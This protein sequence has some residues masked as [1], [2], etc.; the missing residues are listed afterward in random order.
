MF[1]KF[2]QIIA[3]ATLTS[4]AAS[5]QDYSAWYANQVQNQNAY[6]NQLTNSVVQQ[7]MQNPYVQR[8]YQAHL[9][10]GGG[11]SFEQ[12]C[13]L[14]GATGGFSQAGIAQY[15]NVTRD[16]VA[17]EQRAWSGYQNAQNAYADARRAYSNGYSNIQNERGNNL[18]GNSTYWTQNGNPVVLPHTWQ[19]GYHNH[20][21]QGYYVN[22][23]YQYYQM[24]R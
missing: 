7:N 13:Y 18:Q 6:F 17:R 1:K 22:P 19:P 9:A 4:A 24:G 21:G 10:Q 8:A 3:L 2:A 16:N 11:Y 15:N 23:S 20:Q 12:F 14:Y 5:A